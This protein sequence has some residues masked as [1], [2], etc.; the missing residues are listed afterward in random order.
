M[1]AFVPADEIAP[2]ETARAGLPHRSLGE[3]S[4]AQRGNTVAQELRDAKV[5]AMGQQAPM[6]HRTTPNQPS[7]RRPVARP[8]AA[9]AEPIGRSRQ[10]QSSSA[11]ALGERP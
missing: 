2:P 10:F 4:N 7:Q 6:F 11:F 8:R 5:K 1:Q 3:G 9:A